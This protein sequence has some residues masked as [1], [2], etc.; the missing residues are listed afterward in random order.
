MAHLLRRTTYGP[1]E[2]LLAEVA[3]FPNLA[4]PNASVRSKVDSGE[5]RH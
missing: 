1:T 2:A 5:L 4:L 3:A